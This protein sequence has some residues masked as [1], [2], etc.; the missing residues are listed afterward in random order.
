M[1]VILIATILFFSL[2][3]S[4]QAQSLNLCD[5]LNK[6]KTYKGNSSYKQ[7]IEGNEGWIFRTKTDFEDDF[8]I[9]S[10]LKKRF[11]RLHKAFNDQ[12]MD[13]VI[14]LLPTR[15]MMHHDKIDYPDYDLNKAVS[16]YNEVVKTLRDLEISVAAVDNFKGGQDFFYKRDHH[17]NAAGAKLLAEKVAT[18]IKKLPAYADI[19]KISYKTDVENTL[20]HEGTFSDF[21]N[22][23]CGLSIPAEEVPA[24][25]TYEAASGEDLF[26]DK[27][28]P[29]II[30][31]GT[32]NS[33]QEASHANFDGFLKEYIGADVENNS[34]SGGGVDTGMLDWLS[35]PEYKSNKPK[36]VIWEIPIYQNFKGGPFYRQAIPAVYGECK[37]GEI[38]KETADI[39]GGHFSVFSDIADKNISGKDHY[40]HIAFSDFKERKFRLTTNYKD[41]TKEPFDIRRSKFYQP[42]G[43]FYLEFD[44]EKENVIS[45]IDGLVPEDTTGKVI[46]SICSFPQQ[47][48]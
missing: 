2:S 17:W 33:T 29:D 42:D 27:A 15:G 37:G 47:E 39:K 4:A 5:D 30:L 13:L 35:N 16:S 36:I 8:K 38:A 31:I 34:I 32:S 3:Y 14:A 24:Y 12:G 18:E 9:N 40:M 6:D 21:A 11:A 23:V 43:I 48:A 41:K 1:R 46:V 22:E 44:Q 19:P 45:S 7:L 20:E 10:A 26:N 28:R 25:K